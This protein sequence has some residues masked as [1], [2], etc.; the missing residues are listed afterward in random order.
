MARTNRGGVAAGSLSLL[1]LQRKPGSPQSTL[2]PVS[3][4]STLALEGSHLQSCSHISHSV[5]HSKD[6]LKP[7]VYDVADC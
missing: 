3:G 6:G 1:C 7:E 4:Q 5:E 2:K